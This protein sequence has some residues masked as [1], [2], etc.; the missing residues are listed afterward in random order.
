MKN[1][2]LS[3]RIRADTA[4]LLRQLVLG[5]LA[6]EALGLVPEL[7]LQSHFK[8]PTQL[9]PFALLALTLLAVGLV[10]FRAGRASLRFFQVAMLLLAAGGLAGLGFHLS[11]NLEYA[12]ELNPN[13]PFLPLLWKALQRGAPVLA[14]GTLVQM[15]L[16]GLVFTVR[17]PAW[18][19]MGARVGGAAGYRGC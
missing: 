11:G 8:A 17:H 14:P 19:Q 1:E 2:S 10:H 4:L 16:L 13:L 3:A 7:L 18:G 15:G 5:V 6:F 12:R 9:I